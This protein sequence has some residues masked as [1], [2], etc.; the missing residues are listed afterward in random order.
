[1]A[2]LT[3]PAPPLQV[4]VTDEVTSAIE[5]AIATT[6]EFLPRLVGSL[7]I[8][9]LGWLVGRA[10]GRLVAR[11]VDAV[12]IDDMVLDTPLGDVLGGTEQS[13]S[14]AFGT[15]GRWFVYALAILAAADVLA[16]E[17][18]SA[19]IDDAVSYLPAF[20]AGLLIVVLGFVVADFVG[21]AI[22]RTRAA[23]ET[24]YTSW[25]ATG[26]R[27]FLYF[28]VTVVGL[29]T[30]GV[31]VGILYVFA[32][33]LAWGVAAAIAIGAGVAL[34]WG[35]KDFVAN[36]IDSWAGSGRSAVPEPRN[37]GQTDGGIPRGRD[38]GPDSATGDDDV[39][40]EE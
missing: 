34:G 24:N 17:T 21:D 3:S 15:L 32:R 29:E 2:G 13:V 30:M 10:V 19:W 11:V 7:L 26:T 5:A 1:M 28:V 4:D 35:G 27:L 23:T 38:P 12:E 6:I 18:L 39:G 8:L 20:V 22:L 33:A 14:D 37:V 25:F 40:T 16:I 31:D 9:L 36:N